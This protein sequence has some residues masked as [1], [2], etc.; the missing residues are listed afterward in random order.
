MAR[1][2]LSA[3]QSSAID[4]TRIARFI[5]GIKAIDATVEIKHFLLAVLSSQF[6]E[7]IQKLRHGYGVPI[8]GFQTE[9]ALCVWFNTKQQMPSPA[10]LAIMRIN[11]GKSAARLEG[12]AEKLTDI[13]SNYRIRVLNAIVHVYFFHGLNEPSLLL[14]LLHREEV[15]GLMTI[16]T[17]EQSFFLDATNK[18]HDDMLEIKPFLKSRG[19]TEKSLEFAAPRNDEFYIH[20]VPHRSELTQKQLTDFI[21]MFFSQIKE[22]FHRSHTKSTASN[23]F[24]QHW[25]IYFLHTQ[26]GM[27]RIKINASAPTITGG[28]SLSSDGFKKIVKRMDKQIKAIKRDN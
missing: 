7:D 19:M 1:Q 14:P 28:K 12:L 15:K 25:L 20:I 10:S 13:F 6:Q 3:R 22:E 5:S 2:I 16:T 4:A 23:D 27:S 8:D 9:E 11:Y 18:W 24:G 21:Q 17:P 26:C